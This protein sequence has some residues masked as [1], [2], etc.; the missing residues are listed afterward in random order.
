MNG[1]NMSEV[2]IGKC[3]D[4]ETGNKQNALMVFEHIVLVKNASDDTY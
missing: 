2:Y 4:D 1:K 3:H